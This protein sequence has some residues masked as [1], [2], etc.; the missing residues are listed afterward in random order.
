MQINIMRKGLTYSQNGTGNR[1]VFYLQ[2]C[3]MLCPWCSNPEGLAPNGTLLTHQ[4]NLM[5]DACPSGRI[6]EGKIDRVD[7]ADCTSLECVTVNQNPGLSFSCT[8]VEVQDLIDEAN[9]SRSLFFDGGGVTV[10]GGEPTLQFEALKELLTGLRAIGI[11]TAIETNGANPNLP[12]LFPL[13]NLMIIDFKHDDDT[14]HTETTGMS[15]KVIMSNIKAALNWHPNVL[16][17][18]PLIAS[19]NADPKIIHRFVAFFQ[20]CG[21]GNARFELLKYHE[22]GRQKWDSCGLEYTMNK[23]Y[24]SDSLFRSLENIYKKAG[25]NVIRS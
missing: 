12:E 19:F 16:I 23:G 13:V 22:Y 4:N 17:R 14:I 7:C 2:G 11:H 15:N 24:I 6:V 18:T 1:M 5:D 3:D 21:A 8:T 9:E 20:E 25:L 10:S